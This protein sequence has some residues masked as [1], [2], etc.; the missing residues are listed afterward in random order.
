MNAREQ[1]Q[2]ISSKLVEVQ[3]EIN[4][5]EH[6][7]YTTAG[8]KEKLTRLKRVRRA[9]D[10]DLDKLVATIGK[11]VQ[12][13]LWD[14]VAAPQ[15][16]PTGLEQKPFGSDDRANADPSNQSVAKRPTPYRKGR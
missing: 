2:H 5:L 12:F 1:A 15:A 3:A 6:E 7:L 11:P 4:K 14:A 9:L 13:S 10:R 16:A 8:N